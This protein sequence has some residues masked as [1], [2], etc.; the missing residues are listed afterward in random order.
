MKKK[1]RLFIGAAVLL[2]WLSGC[3]H[4]SQEEK[5]SGI[6]YDDLTEDGQ[7]ME[8]QG[9]TDEETIQN[10]AVLLDEKLDENLL[11]HAELTMPDRT[12]Y[13]YAAQLK[14][15]DYDKTQK[16]I[17]QKAE[18][19][20]GGEEGTG[21]IFYQRNDFANHLS[22]YCSYAGEQGMAE[23]KELS[24]L[25][26]E[27]AV[28]KVQSLMEQLEVGGE[29]GTPD[30]AAMNQ[31]DFAKAK[32]VIMEDDS[33]KKI[34][35][36]KGYGSDTFDENLEAY[37]MTFRV[38]ENGIPFYRNEPPLR[39]TSGRALAHPA[40]VEVLL[41][42]NGF[43]MITMTGMLEPYDGQRTEAAMIGGEGIK[44]ALMK[45]FGD[46]ILTSEYKAVNIRMEYFPLIKEGSFTEVDLIPAWCIDFE[47]DG[48]SVEESQYTIRINAVTGEEISRA[49]YL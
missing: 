25:S 37:W 34:L 47:I 7:M 44:E 1:I 35:S 15:F 6:P 18:G 5:Q 10:G 24:F 2:A 43:E 28:L 19:T 46:V 41:S 26:K 32:T 39:Q 48:A 40:A 16:A 12:L 36:S 8:D 49:E 31:A 27:E 13:E 23:E 14:K 3:A 9:E 45:K 33:Y 4:T 17:G 22:T 29:L 42:N 30:V 21:S 20:V 11:I 38:E